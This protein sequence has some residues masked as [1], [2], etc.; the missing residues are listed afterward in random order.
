MRINFIPIVSGNIGTFSLPRI[1]LEESTL[2]RSSSF[3]RFVIE[4][5]EYKGRLKPVFPVRPIPNN[6]MSIAPS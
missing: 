6:S 1:S 3:I 4:E 2:V 5:T